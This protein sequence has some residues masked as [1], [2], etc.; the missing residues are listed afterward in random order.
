MTS[1]NRPLSLLYFL[2][3]NILSLSLSKSIADSVPASNYPG[4]T[5][6]GLW[7]EGNQRLIKMLAA[8]T[9]RWKDS[10]LFYFFFICVSAFCKVL[11]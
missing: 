11:L 9:S 7:Q 2:I 5:G 1:V 8:T 10:E 4:S 6:A 3:Y